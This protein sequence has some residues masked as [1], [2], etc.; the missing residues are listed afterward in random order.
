MKA[1]LLFAK[2]SEGQM[3]QSWGSVNGSQSAEFWGEA[4]LEGVNQQN[5]R[6]GTWA[7]A[8]LSPEDKLSWTSIGQLLKLKICW[9]W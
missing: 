4:N 6:S 9:H 3:F 8:E 1:V 2:Y 5:G 7:S